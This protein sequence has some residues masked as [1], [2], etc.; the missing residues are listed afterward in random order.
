MQKQPEHILENA[1]IQWQDSGAPYSNHFDDIYFS[2]EG[3][4]D[5]TEHVFITGNALSQRWQAQDQA[6]LQGLEH[7]QHF[8]I[9]EL[10]FGTGLN[11]LCCWRAWRALAPKALSLHYIACEKFPLKLEALRLALKSWPELASLSEQFLAQYPDHSHGYHRLHFQD[12]TLGHSITLDLYYGDAEQMLSAQALRESA[13]VDAWFL[14]GFAPKLNPQMWSPELLQQLARLSKPGT[15]LASYSVAGTVVRGVK[16]AG[17]ETKKLKGHGKKRH[18]LTAV[19]SPNPE[20]ASTA[21]PN[22][23]QWL[24][25]PLDTHR[26]VKDVVVIGAG[27]AGCATAY[28][29]ACKGFKVLVL[30]QSKQ[31]ANGA[32]GNRQAVLQCR[33]SNADNGNRQFNLQAFLFATRQFA[34]LQA[35]H[36]EINW[37]ACGVINLESAFKSRQERGGT[38]NHAAYAN[39]I[40]H[41]ISGNHG[42]D[43]AG[44]PFEGE[45]NYIPMGG[46]LNPAQLCHAYLQHPNIRVQLQSKVISIEKLEQQWKVSLEDATLAAIVADAVVIANSV[47]ATQLNQTATLPIVPIRGQVSYLRANSQSEQL[48][49]VVCGRSY[50][51]PSWQGL[52]SVGASYSKKFDDLALTEEEHQQNFEGI[53]AYLQSANLD[54][55]SIEGGRASVRATSTDRMPMVGPV[56][57]FAQL[58]TLYQGSGQDKRKNPGR[59]VPVQ[60]GLYLSVSHGSHGLCNAPLA[61]E[62]IASLIANELLPIQSS[63]VT[64]LHPA[65]FAMR[66]LKR[67]GFAH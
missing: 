54:Y 67:Q 26:H 34:Y 36:P 20:Q 10:G 24:D 23:A 4:L 28:S 25:L 18:M 42:N 64:A 53:A 35:Q 32:S 43:V 56:P 2:S 12:K 59:S 52:H 45:A 22:A 49:S 21:M 14:D 41:A 44:L 51:S 66:T 17:F 3:G 40:V 50:I 37:H 62:Y 55:A 57:D 16:A 7:S 6:L 65:R 47:A 39:D 33:L 9:A 31:I 30:E 29:L 38:L 58:Q 60:E 27:L 8:T 15:T 46:Y 61:G 13:K 19:F 11:F 5:E 1:D 48:T 63:V